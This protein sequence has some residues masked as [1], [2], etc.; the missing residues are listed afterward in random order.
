MVLNKAPADFKIKKPLY[1]PYKSS[2]PKKK[3]MVFV[4]KD[5]NKRLIHFGLVGMTDK[6][7][8]ASPAQVR[9][10]RARSGGIRDK[11]GNLTKSDKNSANF[12]ARKILW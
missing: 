11:Q 6:T 5:G 12:W 7:R 4:K 1:T 10:Y 2:N 3:G 8:G 9:S